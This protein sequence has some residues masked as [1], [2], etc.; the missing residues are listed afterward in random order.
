MPELP[1]AAGC[2]REGACGGFSTRQQLAG[3]DQVPVGLKNSV[4][5][6]LN[7]GL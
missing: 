2:N 1:V 6:Y 4:L 3:E 7:H 5:N